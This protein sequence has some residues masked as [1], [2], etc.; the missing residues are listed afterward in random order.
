MLMLTGLLLVT[1]ACS[2]ST[3]SV[4]P[5]RINARL[6]DESLLQNCDLAVQL[7][8]SLTQAQAETG[9]RAD[10]VALAE[11]R[12][13]HAALAAWARGTVEILNGDD[14]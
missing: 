5:D 12:G 8:G 10:R 1:A 13:R 7:A 11:C 4:D 6:P 9:W 14:E 2:A 3:R